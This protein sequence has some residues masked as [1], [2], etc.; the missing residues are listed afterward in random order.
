MGNCIPYNDDNFLPQPNS[1]CFPVGKPP[2]G[3][4]GTLSDEYLKT[5][6]AS[7]CDTPTKGGFAGENT[8]VHAQYRYAYF[9]L[10]DPKSNIDEVMS[11]FARVAETPLEKGDASVCAQYIRVARAF[12]DMYPDEKGTFSS[13]VQKTK[14]LT[15][16]YPNPADN[17]LNIHVEKGAYSLN[18][19]D[20]QGKVVYTE[21]AE[22]DI[23]INTSAWQSGVYQVLVTDKISG[24]KTV[25]KVVI[26]RY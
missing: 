20:V 15:N 21:E 6:P 2:K 1:K 14:T 18:I 12:T 5:S 11:S 4:G 25:E 8:P 10:F 13:K 26:T 19:M 17:I 3:G 22:G 23:V 9:G 7:S 24:Q 16:V